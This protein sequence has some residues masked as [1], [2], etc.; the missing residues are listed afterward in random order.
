MPT[1]TNKGQFHWLNNTGDADWSKVN[2]K[3]KKKKK[4]LKLNYCMVHFKEERSNKS[5]RR[6]N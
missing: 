1:Y 6:R 3:K 5:E 4:H 2:P